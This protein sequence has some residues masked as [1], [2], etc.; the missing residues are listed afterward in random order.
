MRRL[1][2]LSIAAMLAVAGC[3]PAD[4]VRFFALTPIDAP[5]SGDDS[6][7]AIGVL[8]IG[9]A[10]YLD[11][12]GIVIRTRPNELAI[13]SLH[14]WIEPLDT[15]AR[16]VVARNLGLLLGTDQV[17]LLPEQRLMAMDYAV[18]IAIERFEIVAGPEVVLASGVAALSA[19]AAEA[20][21]EEVVLEARWTL[22]EGDERTVL[23][24]APSRRVVLV[25][26]PPTF[27]Q[28]IAAMSEALAGLS[29]SIAT[30]IAARR[31]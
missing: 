5:P 1:L 13:S 29:R 21:S 12:S 20:P 15:Q 10:S 26:S 16:R 3:T 28:R 2:I 22:F 11:R 24:T 23:R 9:L 17:F 18:E 30:E 7:L 27:E 31:Q 6:D 4:P 8:P 14:N 25:G 19:A